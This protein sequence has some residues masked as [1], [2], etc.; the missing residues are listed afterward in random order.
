MHHLAI[1]GPRQPQDRTHIAWIAPDQD[2]IRRFHGNVGSRSDGDSEIRLHQRRRIVDAVAYHRHGEATPLQL[3]DFIRFLT[4]QHFGEELRDAKPLRNCLSDALCVACQHNRLDPETGKLLDRFLGLGPH[5][6]GKSEERAWLAVADHHDDGLAFGF[7][8]FEPRMADWL[9]LTGQMA[10]AEDAHVF[11]LDLCDN[12]FASDVTYLAR[13]RNRQ[14]AAH[15]FGHD[16][17]GDRMLRLALGGG[18]EGQFLAFV[19]T[20]KQH[21]IADTETPLGQRAG[22]VED[23]RIEIACPLEGSTITDQQSG[24][25]AEGGAD[26]HHQRNGEPER[27]RAGHDHYRYH[28]SNRELQSRAQC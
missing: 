7:E 9:A 25:R 21:E 26:R 19:E 13:L 23:H 5:N 11:A 15:S 1:G 24:A 12:P 4:G 6:V 16:A 8:F 14:L 18:G 20:S 22:L 17:L 3:L 27:M 10:R 2:D 28:A